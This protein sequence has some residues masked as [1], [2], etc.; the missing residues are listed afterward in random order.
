MEFCVEQYYQA[1][2]KKD[3]F[4]MIFNRVESNFELPN[5]IKL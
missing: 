4:W 3:K 5:Q 2:A 1:Q